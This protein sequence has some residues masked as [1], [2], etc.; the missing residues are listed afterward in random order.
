MKDGQLNIRI[1]IWHGTEFQITI[2]KYLDIKTQVFVQIYEFMMSRILNLTM[3][4]QNS[5]KRLSNHERVIMY[6]FYHKMHE[7]LNF[8]F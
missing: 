1:I 3:S 8:H 2:P 4:I 5:P 6:K 7:M